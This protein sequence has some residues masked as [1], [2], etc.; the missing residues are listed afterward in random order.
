MVYGHTPLGEVQSVNNTV[1]IDTGCVF[2]GKLTCYRYPEREIVQVLAH[3]EY[4]RAAKLLSVASDKRDDMLNI[5]DVLGNKYLYT[6]L[7]S[8]IKINEENLKPLIALLIMN[9]YIG[10]MNACLAFSH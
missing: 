3:E 1:C 9:H 5:D 7:R 6:K 10:F 4:Y 8:N 2:G